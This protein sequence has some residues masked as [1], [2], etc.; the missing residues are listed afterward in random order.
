M[1]SLRTALSLAATFVWVAGA[2]HPRPPPAPVPWTQRVA[3]PPPAPRPVRLT[4]VGTNDVHGWVM[5]HRV[6]FPDGSTAEAGGAATFGGYL[7][8]LRSQN[9]GGVLLLDAGDMFQ[10]NLAVNLTEGAVV[11]D[12]M[13]VLGYHAAALGNHEFDYGPVGPASISDTP[14]QDPFGALKA[15]VAQ[16]RFPLLAANVYEAASGERPAWLEGDGTVLLELNGVRVGVLG[17]VTPSTPRTTN[18][19]NVT[20]L[21]F[22]DLAAE[23]AD[24]AAR[25][26]TRGAQVVVLAVHAGAKCPAGTGPHDLSGCDRGDAELLDM[27]EA[28]PPGTLDAVVGGHTH[29]PLG[30]WVRGTPVIETAGLGRSFGLIE[31]TFDPTSG[32]VLPEKT[33]IRPFIEVCAE[34]DAQSGR[35]ELKP[36]PRGPR[37]ARVP[38]TFQGQPVVP[39]PDVAL[40]VAPALALVD[41]RQR[42]QVGVTVDKPLGRAYDGESALGSLLTDS[43]RTLEAADV[44]LWNSGGLR[45]DLPSGPLTYGSLYEVLPFDNAVATLL[46]TREE[47]G[48]LLG[49]AYAAKK[50]VFQVSGLRVSISR[51][52]G[53]QTVSDFRLAGRRPGRKDALIRVVMPD[54]LARG[55]DGLGPFLKTLPEDRVDL[56]GSRPLNIRDDLL[57]HWQRQGRPLRAPAAG[58]IRIRESPVSGCE[59]PPHAR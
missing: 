13:N 37:A 2:C 44:A 58:R 47:L 27:L 1:G 19:V 33:V 16:A 9:P 6:T 46:L 23:A 8:I 35:C 36:P 31:L 41:A 26:R 39:D 34:V 32:R 14:D 25:L 43:L 30:H 50:G 51:C 57:R 45:A 59:P 29:T 11:V 17:L 56:G 52:G 12:A 40:A 3:P 38:A 53:Q 20:S 4:V 54:F 18:P 7:S 49:Q 28:L 10:G 55:G 42:E 24:G 22:A 5:P 15:R 21:R 48:R